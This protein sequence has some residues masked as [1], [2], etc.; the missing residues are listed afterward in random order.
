[1]VLA[2]VSALLGVYGA[3]SVDA[4]YQITLASNTGTFLVYGMTCL[5]TIMAFAGRHDRHP[6]KHYLIPG[7]GLFMNIAELFGVV[8]LAVKAGGSA[9]KDVYI[10]LAVVLA[11][12]VA[13]AVWVLINPKMRGVKL[14]HDPGTRR[15][16]SSADRPA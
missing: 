7:L 6:I 9:S 10:A 3:K 15:L 11:W 13:G 5:I 4:L 8:Y 14:R 1:M 16:A 2:G 12:I